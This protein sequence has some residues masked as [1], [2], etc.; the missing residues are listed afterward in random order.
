MS[1]QTYEV[2]LDNWWQKP[3][4]SRIVPRTVTKSGWE[5]IR[6]HIEAQKLPL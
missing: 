2:T 6:Y 3:Q 5:R 4:F 1:L